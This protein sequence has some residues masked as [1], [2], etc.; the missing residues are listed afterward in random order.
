MFD[1]LP[2]LLGLM[3]KIQDQ[4]PAHI[5]D[6]NTAL[7][8]LFAAGTDLF[9][10][11]NIRTFRFEEFREEVES[12]NASESPYLYMW[13]ENKGQE[14]SHYH[15]GIY[16]LTIRLDLIVVGNQEI[17][18]M[19]KVWDEDSAS[20]MPKLVA[21]ELGTNIRWQMNTLTDLLVKKVLNNPDEDDKRL[22]WN[23]EQ[24][25]MPGRFRGVEYPESVSYERASQV[26]AIIRMD[27]PTHNFDP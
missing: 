5:T 19:R 24:V 18:V 22:Y 16:M 27:Y 25:G 12:P 21:E 15:N 20:Y 3:D 17:E 2:L 4:M 13:E 7:S 1:A 10:V 9:T 23:G 14:R 26:R 11:E 8:S 6:A